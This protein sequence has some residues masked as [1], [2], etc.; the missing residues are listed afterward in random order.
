MDAR[1]RHSREMLNPTADPIRR[2]TPPS[3]VSASDHARAA[4]NRRDRIIPG[5]RRLRPMCPDIVPPKGLSSTVISAS[6]WAPRIRPKDYLSVVLSPSDQARH[7]AWSAYRKDRRAAPE[8]APVGHR[9]KRG[10][11]ESGWADIEP[12]VMARQPKEWQ[13]GGESRGRCDRGITRIG[14]V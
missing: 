14:Q 4:A 11:L 6:G 9:K 1:R 5:H 10:P 3:P 2:M 13:K 12:T 8:L 7:V